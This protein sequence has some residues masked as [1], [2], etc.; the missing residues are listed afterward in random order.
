MQ[1]G[2]GRG[3]LEIGRYFDGDDLAALLSNPLL[4]TEL[5][6]GQ[7]ELGRVLIRAITGT[8]T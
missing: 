4:E 6:P 3:P 8:D 7:R 5:C 2:F 1:R